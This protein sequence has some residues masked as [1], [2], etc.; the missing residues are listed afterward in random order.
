LRTAVDVSFRL[1]LQ[2]TAPGWMDLALGVPMMDTGAARRELAW[3]AERSS[4]ETLAE[5]LDG[6]AARAGLP[7]PALAPAPGGTML[8]WPAAS[9]EVLDT[10]DA[11]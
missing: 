5:L 2:R 7:T 6:F 3:R 1:R 8:N 9:A 4:T 10:A 11:G